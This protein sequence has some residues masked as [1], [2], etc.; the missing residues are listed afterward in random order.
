MITHFSAAI[1]GHSVLIKQ[2]Y[3][4]DQLNFY[5]S[6]SDSLTFLINCISSTYRSLSLLLSWSSVLLLPVALWLS[7]FLDQ[8]YFFYLSLSDSLTFLIN[9][10]SSTCRSLTLLLSCS[11][12][13]L[14]PVAHWLSFL[15]SSIC[16]ARSFLHILFPPTILPTTPRPEQLTS[17]EMPSSFL[18]YFLCAS[19]WPFCQKI[20]SFS[21]LILLEKIP[22]WPTWITFLDCTK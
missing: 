14:L 17:C 20:F 18:N 22:S 11:T 10:I 19:W 1:W 9:C 7:Y 15:L 21:K 3:F 12:V 6:L 4:L 13:F 5:L 8:L 2:C 16:I